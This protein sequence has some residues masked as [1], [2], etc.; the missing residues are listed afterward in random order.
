MKIY[1]RD[2]KKKLYPYL[3]RKEIIAIKGP[4]QSGK[5]TLLMELFKELSSKKKCLFLTFEKRT[6]LELFES[7]IESF[8]KL[9]TQQYQV[10]LIDE[11][12]YAKKGGEKLKYI[13]DTTSC[14][15]I[16][17]GSSSLELTSETGKYLVGRILFFELFPFS[18]KEF[19]QA[20]D[21]SM[22]KLI[23][24][25]RYTIDSLFLSQKTKFSTKLPI[26]SEGLRMKYNELL[27]QYI[28]FGGYPAVC[29][30]PKEERKILLKGILETYLLR[31]INSL[32]QLA[33]E[34]ELTALARFLGLQIGNLIVY[35][36]LST[37]SR[38]SFSNLRKHL[39]ILKETY[40]ID[41]LYP[42]YRNKRTELVKNP[43]V[44]FVDTGFR[45]MLIDNFS[46]LKT[47]TD[48]GALFEN[49]VFSQLK[50]KLSA[51]S[52]IK[53]W[54]TKSQA[55]VDFVVEKG[56]KVLPVEVKYSLGE[57]IS[58]GKSFHS[59]VEKYQPNHAFVITLN[60]WNKIKI[61]NTYV[62]FIPGFYL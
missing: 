49:Y 52:S 38:L 2:V 58:V 45:N 13:Y 47:R 44:Y 43:K 48:A 6:D 18:F 26:R 36:E 56:G 34:E 54:R 25:T 9:Y 42:Y 8:K 19:L 57:S 55:E 59:F 30:A 20:R 5:T 37:S 62:Y 7:D 60:H 24:Q 27:E 41:I 40:I 10:I 50:R 23:E 28:L 29:T 17:S 33:T 16:I 35:Q 32:L 11:F 3:K 22:A 12:Q 15:F 14:K 1:P 31:D 46:S 39:K 53:F 61:R 21:D 4:R 51:F